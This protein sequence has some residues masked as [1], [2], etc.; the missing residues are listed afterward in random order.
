M[1]KDGREDIIKVYAEALRVNG[2]L[3]MFSPVVTCYKACIS[4][5]KWKILGEREPRKRKDACC[6]LKKLIVRPSMEFLNG[7]RRMAKVRGFL[8]PHP[9]L[10]GR[11]M[12]KNGTEYYC[13]TLPSHSGL[14][15][16]SSR[17]KG[18]DAI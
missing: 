5:S 13:F 15:F 1:I 2:D 16:S 3:A 4:S 9:E 17:L 14:P 8:G 6:A 10:P 7:M 12:V 11:V 18:R